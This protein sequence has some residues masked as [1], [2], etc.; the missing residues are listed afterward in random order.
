MNILP[1][2]LAAALLVIGTAYYIFFER[3][4]RDLQDRIRSLH[5][6]EEK[7]IMDMK[8]ATFEHYEEK[9]TRIVLFFVVAVSIAIAVPAFLLPFPLSIITSGFGAIISLLGMIL[10]NKDMK[11]KERAESSNKPF[12]YATA[13]HPNFGYIPLL[14]RRI[15]N[16]GEV[17]LEQPQKEMVVK[18]VLEVAENMPEF[19]DSGITKDALEESIRKYLDNVHYYRWRVSEVYR[20]LFITKSE[21]KE[22]Q[23]DET[24]RIIDRTIEVDV[25]L[26]PSFLVYAN[27]TDRVFKTKSKKG[28]IEYT[29]R[30]MG[31]YVDIVNIQDVKEKIVN[32][33]FTAPDAMT[34]LVGQIVHLYEQQQW[35]GKQL[36]KE[37]RKREKAEL[38]AD[39]QQ[40]NAAAE[41][42]KIVNTTSHI[43][44]LM[45]ALLSPA[46]QRLREDYGLLFLVFTLGMASMKALD[47][48]IMF[49]MQALG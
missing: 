16:E 25:P 45:L 7:F 37:T 10:L 44:K 2:I 30:T 9:F 49:V 1:I 41:A 47:T 21:F 17:I 34:A 29:D 27:T 11:E 38:L 33:S 31:I 6:D 19:I 3:P 5:F 13:Y 40:F 8:T 32:G 20:I 36:T 24:H 43:L 42:N 26:I 28:D 15:K 22:I 14:L 46:A 39:T 4:A 35:S 23:T 48:I 12:G 18:N